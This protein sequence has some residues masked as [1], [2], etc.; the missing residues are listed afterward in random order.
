MIL[1]RNPTV[2]L[3]QSTSIVEY[4]DSRSI[5]AMNTTILILVLT[6]LQTGNNTGVISSS[7]L[8]IPIFLAAGI[9][10]LVSFIVI[11]RRSTSPIVDFKLLLNK[12]IFPSDI[13]IMI[14]GFSMF[15]LPIS[16]KCP[17]V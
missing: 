4:R 2:M 8:L 16:K 6:Y 1:Y 15:L 17:Y 7:K 5:A 3:L 14:V 11:E 13:M 10:F 12:A 9:I